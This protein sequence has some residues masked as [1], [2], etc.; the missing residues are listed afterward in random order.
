MTTIVSL[1]PR[2]TRAQIEEQPIRQSVVKDQQDQLPTF[3]V[4]HQQKPGAHHI[5]VGCV[6][7]AD[8]EMALVVAKEQYARRGS[9]SSLWVV[10][11]AAIQGTGSADSDIFSTT[12]EKTYRET[13]AYMVRKKVEEFKKQQNED[14][15]R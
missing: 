12:P 5:H 1:D 10:E 4:F 6:H 11:S 14:D 2:I 13:A 3:E 8:A 7:A 15:K 9:C